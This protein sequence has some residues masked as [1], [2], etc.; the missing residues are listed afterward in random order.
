MLRVNVP[1]GGFQ[2]KSFSKF[3][4]FLFLSSIVI[5]SR[6]STGKVG[7]PDFSLIYLSE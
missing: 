3:M 5:K 1:L 4:S 2:Q 7:F 6:L